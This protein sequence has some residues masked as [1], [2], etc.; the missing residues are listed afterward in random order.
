MHL[1]QIVN[2]R[3]SEYRILIFLCFINAESM[4]NMM[5]IGGNE[6]T[7]SKER[8]FGIRSKWKA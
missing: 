5:Q 7:I 1:M 6:E 8:N 4:Q 3:L 2:N